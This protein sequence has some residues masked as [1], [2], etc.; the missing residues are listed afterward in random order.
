MSELPIPDSAE[1]NTVNQLERRGGGIFA[2]KYIPTL[3]QISVQIHTLRFA[4]SRQSFNFWDTTYSLNPIIDRS[5]AGE[6]QKMGLVEYAAKSG[7]M[8]RGETV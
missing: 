5:F 8:G 4:V 6:V 7:G 3:V 1:S 2:C